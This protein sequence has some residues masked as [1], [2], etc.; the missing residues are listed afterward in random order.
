MSGVAHSGCGVFPWR[1]RRNQFSSACRAALRQPRVRVSPRSSSVS[2]SPELPNRAFKAPPQLYSKG[3]GTKPKFVCCIVPAQTP[4][5]IVA[6]Y[7]PAPPESLCSCPSQVHLVISGLV[8]AQPP[9]NSVFLSQPASPESMCSCPSW[10][11]P[12]VCVLPY[13]S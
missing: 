10:T 7:Q 13:V 11:H 4:L 1:V 12:V 5:K 2:M 6:L 3:L 9:L 8:L